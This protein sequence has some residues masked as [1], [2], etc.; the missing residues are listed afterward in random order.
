MRIK[1]KTVP[2]CFEIYF[3]GGVF[4]EAAKALCG[5][6][7]TVTIQNHNYIITHVTHDEDNTGELGFKLQYN[8][9]PCDV[10][11]GRI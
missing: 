4:C 7:G 2:N 11:Q 1:V 3:S 6:A 5:T 8:H 10:A 9:L